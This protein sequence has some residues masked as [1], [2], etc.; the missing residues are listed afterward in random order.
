[1]NDKMTSHTVLVVEDDDGL[2]RLMQKH[3]V[4]EGFCT[5]GAATGNEAISWLGGHQA[6]LLVLDFQLPDMDGKQ[7]IKILREKHQTVPFV[8]VTGQG[9]ERLAVDMLKC[10]ARDYIMKDGA[11]LELLPSVVEQV[12]EQVAREDKLKVAEKALEESEAQYRGIFTATLDAVFVVDFDGSIVDA[13]PQAC[14][15]YGYSAEEFLELTLKELIHPD[16]Q[17]LYDQ[18]RLDM[19]EKGEFQ[20]ESMA[21][22]KDGTIIDVDIRSTMFGFKGRKHILAVFRD[23]SE[24]KWAEEE[25]KLTNQQLR[26]SEQALREREARLRAIFQGAAVGVAL[27]DLGGRSLESNRALQ[28]MLGYDKRELRRKIFTEF[29]HVEDVQESRQV[30]E[31][32]SKGK[33]EHYQIETRYVRK[34]GRPL[35]VRVNASLVRGEANKPNYVISMVQDITDWKRTEQALRICDHRYRSLAETINDGLEMQ[36]EDGQITYVNDRLCQMWGYSREELIGRRVDDLL[37]EQDGQRFEQCLSVAGP[38]RAESTEVV[39]TAKSGQKVCT[40]VSVG[41][42]CDAQGKAT[43][44]FAVITDLRGRSQAEPAGPQS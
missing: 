25:L 7:V 32:L 5:A 39:W 42:L 2:L 27:V 31:Q 29:T 19:Q 33:V 9:D 12:I 14:Q 24:R 3:L 16:H 43:G 30:F 15:M 11:F 35:W 8:L 37:D 4:R 10:G 36:D 13:N 6:D 40:R 18:L 21:V 22:Q 1:M 41:G 38:D 20:A 34:D 23:V 28:E 44:N 17:H 26:V